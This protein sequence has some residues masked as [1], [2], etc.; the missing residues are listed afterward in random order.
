[1]GTLKNIRPSVVINKVYTNKDAKSKLYDRLG[2]NRLSD[3]LATFLLELVIFCMVAYFC[4]YYLE[5]W[6]LQSSRSSIST[7]KQVN[8]QK[9][10]KY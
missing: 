1:M 2:P 9:A 6:R 3:I 5:N 8:I 4:Y 10:I 7:N